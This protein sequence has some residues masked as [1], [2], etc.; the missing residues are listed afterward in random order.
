MPYINVKITREGV[1]DEQK[2]QLIQG[3]TDL[4]VSILNKNPSTTFV[5][6]EEIAMENGGI[7]GLPVEE[8]RSLSKASS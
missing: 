4:V 1:T 3:I 8:Y 6:I 2:A 7:G 5:V